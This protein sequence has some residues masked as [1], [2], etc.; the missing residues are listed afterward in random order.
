MQSPYQHPERKPLHH[1]QQHLQSLDEPKEL[2]DQHHQ[3]TQSLCHHHRMQ[4][5]CEHP[6]KQPLHHHNQHVQS[7]YQHPHQR[8][9]ECHHRHHVQSLDESKR[10]LCEQKQ[11]LLEHPQHR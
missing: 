4:L 3:Q 10:L 8:Q 7:Q 11:S 9:W 2:V 5:V 6:W 1:H